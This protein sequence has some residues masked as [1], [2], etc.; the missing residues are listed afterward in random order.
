MVVLMVELVIKGRGS[1]KKEGLAKTEGK[2][3]QMKKVGAEVVG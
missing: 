2:A 3:E 1:L